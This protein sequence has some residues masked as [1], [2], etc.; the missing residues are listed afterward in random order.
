MRHIRFSEPRKHAFR[1]GFLKGLA[2]PV[3]LFGD[4]EVDP[5]IRDFEPRPLEQ[6]PL[7]TVA[8]DWRKVGEDLRAAIAQHG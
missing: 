2:A 3:N 5:L 4:F 1:H 8:D 7:G 6:R